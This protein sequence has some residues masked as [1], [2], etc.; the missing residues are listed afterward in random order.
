MKAKWVDLDIRDQIVKFIEKMLK[1]EIY[2][3]TE[4]IKL[5]GINRSRYY[6]WVSRFGIVNKYCTNIPT[7]NWLTP[8]EKSAILEYV[9]KNYS[10][11]ALYL[12]MG[13][14]R[15][16]YEMLDKNIAAVS[17]SSVYWI[18]RNAGL[19]NKYSPIKMSKKGTGFKQPEKPHQEWHT[20]IK[21]VN[22]LGMF[23]FLITVMDGYSRYLLHHELRL[24]MTEYDV[25]LTIQR[26]LEK[27]PNEHPKLISDNGPQ[28]ISRDFEKF[29]K[30]AELQ[31]VKTSV[32]YP[33]ANGKMERFYLTLENECLQTKTMISIEDAR[34]I[35]AE[36]IDYYNKSRLHSSLFYLT[37]EDFLMGRVEQKIQV[38]EEKMLEAKIWRGYY[39][40]QKKVV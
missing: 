26:A 37:P 20:D 5:L 30:E 24:N 16:A 3:T 34:K 22:V 7:Y 6:E 21:Y 10:N 9:K 12:R 38:R 15:I 27:Y 35:I 40:S 8:E 11:N 17:P 14:R 1:T 23:L 25:E 4:L 29:L 31:H 36:F 2:T 18:L 13:Y 39:W 33:P 32:G 28:Y 19:L